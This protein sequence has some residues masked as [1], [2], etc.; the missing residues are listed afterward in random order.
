MN[1]SADDH[2]AD[3]HSGPGVQVFRP[4]RLRI[5]GVALSVILIVLVLVGWFALPVSLRNE[6]TLSQILTLLALVA[7]LELVMLAVASSYVRADA[8]GL[9][10]RNGLR[11]YSVGWERVHKVMLRPGD[12]W[13]IVL[14]TPADGSAF[15]VDLDAE[16]RQ[17]MGIQANDGEYAHKAVQSLRR[18]HSLGRG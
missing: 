7:F 11:R 15:E 6:F 4:R 9:R 5:L 12:P 17:L 8:A 3:D 16:K 13:A 10:F 2:S 14:L 18:R 1:V